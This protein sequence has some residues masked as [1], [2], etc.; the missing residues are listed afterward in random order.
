MKGVVV[1][2][3]SLT[4]KQVLKKLPTRLSTKMKQNPAGFTIIELLVVI[5][6][7][8]IIA[9]I[10]LPTATSFQGEKIEL[11]AADIAMALRF[12]RDDA[13][14]TGEERGVRIDKTTGQ[15]MVYSTILATNP[16]TVDEILYN[17]LTKQPYD[18][19]IMEDALTAGV[20]ISNTEKPFNY[21][22]N[23]SKE[24][25]IFF[26]ALGMPV[27]IKGNARYHLESG[28]IKLADGSDTRSIELSPFTGR[29]SIQ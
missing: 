12:A 9:R 22:S 8:G 29:I 21:R 17:P 5:L 14:R 1:F 24:E 27:F 26:D 3:K 20:R 19:N 6:I 2:P 25:D 28:A 18:F 4:K 16:V 23:A 13:I 7:I 10:A 15:V 11:A